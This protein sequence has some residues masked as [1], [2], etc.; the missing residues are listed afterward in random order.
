VAVS[1]YMRSRG[2]VE[3]VPVTPG[4][5][6]PKGLFAVSHLRLRHSPAGKGRALT[7]PTLH[8]LTWGND[9]CVPVA[10][11]EPRLRMLVKKALCFLIDLLGQ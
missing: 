8:V 3:T 11:Y 7:P 4:P 1:D 9:H 5:S 10:P 6:H 2:S